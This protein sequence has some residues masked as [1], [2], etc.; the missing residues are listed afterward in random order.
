[1]APNIPTPDQLSEN[2]Y[3]SVS[4]SVLNSM[5][6]AQSQAYASQSIE[7]SC[8]DEAVKYVNDQVIECINQLNE[9][10]KDKDIIKKLCKPFI[11]CNATNISLKSSLN[12]TDIISQTA[13]IQSTIKNSMTNNVTQDMSALLTNLALFGESDKQKVS[14]ITDIVSE[15]SQSITQEVYN[16]FTQQ[17]GLTLTNYQA[18][19]ITL[20]S[21]SDIIN[22]SIQNIKGVSSIVTELSNDI[23]QR[24]SSNTDTLSTWVTSIMFGFLAIFVILFI[25]LFILKRNDTR[26]FI[27]LI[28]PYALFIIGVFII[29][30]VHMIVK[31]SYIMI[32]NGT[33][34]TK[35]NNILLGS[36][37]TVFAI[38]LGFI[39]I[40][41]YK[42]IK[43]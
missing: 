8:D 20:S 10:G 28:M 34:Y 35:I 3:K 9:L 29:V 41:Y 18:N 36:W 37:C 42:F 5:Q 38:L 30:G 21:V 26:D 27:Q 22:N 33:K 1:M 19:N 13:I 4:N 2:I 11:E 40:I 14:S 43:N 25:I 23:V 31:P 15:N 39:E 6:L 7:I 32:N 16:T 24:M 17:Q 12:I